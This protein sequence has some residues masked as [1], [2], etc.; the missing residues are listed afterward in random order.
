VLRLGG[1]G[2]CNG[3]AGSR[4][5][6]KLQK[7]RL[8]IREEVL[9]DGKVREMQLVGGGVNNYYQACAVVQD[10]KLAEQATFDVKSGQFAFD[11]CRDDLSSLS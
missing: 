1:A 8:V 11:L 2:H 7:L 5:F 6:Q 9:F 4:K 10:V 3:N